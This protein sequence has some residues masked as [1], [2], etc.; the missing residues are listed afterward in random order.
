ML[1]Q[2]QWSHLDG[3]KVGLSHGLSPQL[4]FEDIP[5]SLGSSLADAF[6]VFG[7]L[8]KYLA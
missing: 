4:D 2:S 1:G 8:L 6:V 7:L 5:G 3:N